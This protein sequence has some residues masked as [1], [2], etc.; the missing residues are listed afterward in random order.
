MPNFVLFVIVNLVPGKYNEWVK[1][2]KDTREHVTTSEPG[3][4]SY[5][6]GTS[7]IH[8]AENRSKSTVVWAEDD[9]Q[10]VILT[11]PPDVPVYETVHG[12]LDKTTDMK[13]CGLI[14][15]MKIVTAPGKREMVLQRL[16]E[17]AGW[18]EQNEL[19]TYTFLVH[20]GVGEGVENE[21][22]I[23]ERYASRD[24]LEARQNAE[25]VVDFF[26]AS[27]EEIV[28]LDGHGYVPNDAG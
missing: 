23:L 13:E 6:F 2:T 19:D 7:E 15:D 27:K 5:Y 20:K 10:C 8:G 16:K 26:A 17:L 9:G 12:F 11:T 3:C 4:V 21:V 22:R 28:R 14:W 24:A 18:V 25:P 1:I